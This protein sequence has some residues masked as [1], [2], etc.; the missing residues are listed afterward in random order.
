ME[1]I[2]YDTEYVG[3]SCIIVDPKR[4]LYEFWGFSSLSLRN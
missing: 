2:S 1:K 3:I 4:V